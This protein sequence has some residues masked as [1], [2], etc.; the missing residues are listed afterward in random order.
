MS[1][2]LPRFLFR[3]L[4]CSFVLSVFIS[5]FPSFCLHLFLYSFPSFLSCCLGFCGS[6]VI[7]LFLLFFLLFFLSF[8]RL[9]LS[10]V[11]RGRLVLSD[12]PA[13]TAQAP[14]TVE[15]VESGSSWRRSCQDSTST[16]TGA[17][18]STFAGIRPA[19]PATV[20]TIAMHHTLTCLLVACARGAAK[21]SGREWGLGRK[22]GD[23][24][25]ELDV[26]EVCAR[27]VQA[28][29]R[30]ETRSSG[31]RAGGRSDGLPVGRWIGRAMDRPGGRFVGRSI[32]LA[33]GHSVDQSAA[34]SGGR[35]VGS[36]DERRGGRTCGR[37]GGWA[38]SASGLSSASRCRAPST[39]SPTSSLGLV[40]TARCLGFAR[41]PPSPRRAP[42]VGG[43][44]GGRPGGR[45]VGRAAGRA[46]GRPAGRLGG[47]G[48]RLG[49]RR[50][51]DGRSGGRSAPRP[52]GRTAGRADARIGGRAGRRTEV[53]TGG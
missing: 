21:K 40:R 6:F 27:A 20:A 31:G 32:H 43:R 34:R 47:T 23:G 44:P 33:G 49:G 50:C 48:G 7:Y 26:D 17:L 9:P 4:P 46:V 5:V 29:H 38:A 22:R 14:G 2:V 12:P 18:F 41:K 3:N 37:A 15:R 19:E 28:N 8:F 53:R 11:P 45:A 42:I 35:A 24:E 51:S 1:F 36:S 39:S 52:F 16:F 25:C 13:P 10:F 30:S